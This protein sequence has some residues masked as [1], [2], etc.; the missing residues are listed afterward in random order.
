MTQSS[1]PSTSNYLSV[2]VVWIVIHAT[3]ADLERTLHTLNG[4]PFKPRLI[5]VN[6]AED[7]YTE[8]FIGTF[9]HKLVER[10][11]LINMPKTASIY[12][13]IAVSS[14]FIGDITIMYT[15]IDGYSI[16]HSLIQSSAESF[17]KNT[18]QDIFIFKEKIGNE[19]VFDSARGDFTSAGFFIS[20]KPLNKYL[21]NTELKVGTVAQGTIERLTTANRGPIMDPSLF[22]YRS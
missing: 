4:I 10:T 16:N 11:V 3:K 17:M 5:L 9:G 6:K 14:N 12:D 21:S 8:A 20:R 15:L 19:D 18:A 22:N 1:E 7:I 13:C 2:N